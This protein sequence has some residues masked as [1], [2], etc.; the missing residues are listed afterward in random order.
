MYNYLYE[1]LSWDS[2]TFDYKVARIITSTLSPS[3]LTELL[4]Y[5]KQNDY[6]LIYW[7]VNPKNVFLNIFAERA[8]GV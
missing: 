6:R 4:I 8:G 1:H 7:S 3:T 5:L 2:T